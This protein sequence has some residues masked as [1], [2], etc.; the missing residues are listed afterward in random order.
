MLRQLS[1][2]VT[3]AS[4]NDE[5]QAMNTANIS[6]RLQ[7][8]AVAESGS[9]QASLSQQPHEQAN[10]EGLL[11]MRDVR[12]EGMTLQPVT[13][14]KA[15]APLLPRPTAPF[16]RT[17]RKR[18]H[19]SAVYYSECFL[20]GI[21]PLVADTAA[22]EI[23]GQY[24]KW[25]IQR[26]ASKAETNEHKKTAQKRH[27]KEMDDSKH[28]STTKRKYVRSSVGSLSAVASSSDQ[29]SISS[30]PNVVSVTSSQMDS[31]QIVATQ[32]R[33][34]I[35]PMAHIST[36]SQTSKTSIE[37]VKNRLIEDLRQSGGQ[38]DTPEA[39]QCMEILQT[40]YARCGIQ[41]VDPSAF[42]GNWLTI[43]KPEYT[44]C[45]GTGATGESLYALGRIGFDMF[46]PT[47]LLCSVQASFNNV[48]PIDPKNPGRPLHVPKKLLRDIRKGECR[49]HSYE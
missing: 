39:L 3:T 40:Y 36:L 20:R 5:N 8:P 22:V 25:W 10:L 32:S 9:H 17:E 34:G 12:C 30:G 21:E 44:E 46:K 24:D 4:S 42:Q 13:L 29:A 27:R 11:L 47:G 41:K 14:D 23:Q 7:N 38:I 33:D 1:N 16:D 35:P 31:S 15:V 37:F 49:L 6:G 45:K 2:S 18:A 26:T 48:Q 28:G 43:S 19:T